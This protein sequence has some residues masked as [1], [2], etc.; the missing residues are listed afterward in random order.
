MIHLIKFELIT[1]GMDV[2][3]IRFKSDTLSFQNMTQKEKN[4]KP[5]HNL[6]SFLNSFS[7]FPHLGIYNSEILQQNLKILIIPKSRKLKM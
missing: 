6:K 7:K 4:N 5:D 1:D 2:L 3:W